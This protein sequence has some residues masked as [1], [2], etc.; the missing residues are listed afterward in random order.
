MYEAI[1]SGIKYIFPESVEKGKNIAWKLLNVIDAVYE[2]KDRPGSLQRLWEVLNLMEYYTPRGKQSRSLK[3][4][5]PNQ[6]L[7]LVDISN[8]TR[9]WIEYIELA[10]LPLCEQEKTMGKI[11]VNPN[12]FVCFSKDLNFVKITKTS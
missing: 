11:R 7:E 12:G 8:E 5:M 4:I 3:C 9:D 2:E 1:I 6:V 10:N